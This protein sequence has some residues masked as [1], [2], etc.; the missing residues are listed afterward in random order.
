MIAALS[1]G[2]NFLQTAKPFSADLRAL[3]TSLVD[4]F[5]AFPITS[6]VAGLITS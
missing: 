6:S 5:D 1:H 4:A 2:E 3:S